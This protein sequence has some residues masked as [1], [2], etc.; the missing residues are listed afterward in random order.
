MRWLLLVSPGVVFCVSWP[1]SYTDDP[2]EIGDARRYIS[3]PLFYSVENCTIAIVG[4]N[5]CISLFGNMVPSP[6]AFYWVEGCKRTVHPDTTTQ[7]RS[8]VAVRLHGA[9]RA[10]GTENVPNKQQEEH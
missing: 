2:V 9:Y 10:I 3:V 1:Y 8:A 6:R 4:E 7:Y 5:F